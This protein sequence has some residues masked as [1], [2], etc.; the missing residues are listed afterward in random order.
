MYLTNAI[1][2]L[3]AGTAIVLFGRA[4]GVYCLYCEYSEPSTI[5]I[6]IQ[7]KYPIQE[8]A[9]QTV[10]SIGHRFDAELVGRMSSRHHYN[11]VI[12]N[13]VASQITSLTIV[14]SIVYSRHISKKTSKLRVTGLW[15]GNS[16]VTGEFP[17]QR[18]S[19]AE[20]VS[21][22]WRHHD[23]SDCLCHLGSIMTHPRRRTKFKFKLV[24]I[25]SLIN[26]CLC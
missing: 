13:T 24:H 25:Y 22:L 21:I 6:R 20:N 14:Y 5:D 9:P 8:N 17:A 11:D 7:N 15:E 2:E 12:M 4:M 26:L 16:P 19:N 23:R 18:A 1:L 10:T 3:K